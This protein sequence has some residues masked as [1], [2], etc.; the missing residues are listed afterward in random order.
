[1]THDGDADGD[2]LASAR[3]IAA[4]HR[5]GETVTYHAAVVWR[6]APTNASFRIRLKRVDLIDA[7]ASRGDIN[8]YL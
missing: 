2:L 3:M 8:L 4:E 5:R 7:D 1:V 6:L